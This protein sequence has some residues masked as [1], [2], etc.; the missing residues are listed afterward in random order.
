MRA[1]VFLRQPLFSFPGAQAHVPS[2][3]VVLE[4]EV[5]PVEGIGLK[6]EITHCL[7]EKGRPLTVTPLTV[8][9]PLD[10]VDNLQLLT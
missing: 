4:G 5:N 1:R 9:V 10:K 8:L 6:V 3:A 7:D 2:A